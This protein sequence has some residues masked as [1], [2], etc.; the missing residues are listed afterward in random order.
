[1]IDNRLMAAISKCYKQIKASQ[2][3]NLQYETFI[4]DL[5]KKF[6]LKIN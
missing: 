6:F 3:Y 5:L 1:M 4:S 2:H